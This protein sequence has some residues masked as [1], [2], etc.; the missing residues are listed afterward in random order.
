M[1]LNKSITAAALAGLFVGTAAS[2][3]AAANSASTETGFTRTNSGSTVQ[4][5]AGFGKTS[6]NFMADGAKH[7]CKGKNDCKGKGGCKTGD[8][9]CKGKN[10]C[11]GK[12]GCATDGKK[13]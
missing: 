2:A 1:K 8:N 10:S 13:G 5:L 3:S 6:V 12:G 4:T 9:G 7:D 11:K